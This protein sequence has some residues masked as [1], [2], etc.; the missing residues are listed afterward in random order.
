VLG[1][2]SQGR[3]ATLAWLLLRND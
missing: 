1:K 3:I 2:L